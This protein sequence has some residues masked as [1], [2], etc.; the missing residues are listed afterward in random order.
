MTDQKL[1]TN[2]VLG[3]LIAALLIAFWPVA[4]GLIVAWFTTIS[5]MIEAYAEWSAKPQKEKDS[6]I[7]VGLAI[8]VFLISG[9][10]YLIY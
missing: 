9:T 10:I 8:L 3:I 4:L 6:D 5:P 1:V 7:R 2:I